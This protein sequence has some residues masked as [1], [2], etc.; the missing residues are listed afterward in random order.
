MDKENT[1]Y[2]L[3]MKVKM[4]DDKIRAQQA[5]IRGAEL[6]ILESQKYIDNFSTERQA[7]LD[8]LQKLGYVYDEAD[9]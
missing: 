3:K 6:S 1:I 2:Y 4:S 5:Q 9:F 7:L 8:M